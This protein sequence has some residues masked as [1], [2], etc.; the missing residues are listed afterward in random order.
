MTVQKIGWYTGGAVTVLILFITLTLLFIP[1][2]AI[3]DAVNRGLAEQEL[4]L[5]AVDFGKALPLGIRGTGWTLSSAKGQ[6]LT[7]DKASIR[8]QLFPLLR[9]K[10]SL[11]I[12]AATGSGTISAIATSAANGSLH[13]EITGMSLEQIPFFSTVSGVRAAGIVNCQ[14]DISGITGKGSGFVKLDARG[15]DLRGIKIGEMPLPDAAYQTVQ[16]MLRIS[17]GTATIE[18]FTLQGDGLYVRL[19]GNIRPGSSLPASPLEMSLEL[20]PRPE[21]LEKQKF[22]FLLLT[23]YLDTPGHYRVPIKGTLGKPLME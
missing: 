10:I 1:S 21:F 19:K 15:V 2:Q 20:M 16:G 5:S 23:K 13:L 17:N 18:S 6:L 8:L 7:L 22:V 3:L 4:T 9:G 11:K 14:A 12:S